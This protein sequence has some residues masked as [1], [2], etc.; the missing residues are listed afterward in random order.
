L[1]QCGS[2][3][4][5]AGIST[6]GRRPGA[7]VRRIT[8]L[9]QAGFRLEVDGAVAVVDP[10]LSPHEHRLIAS[11]PLELAADGVD[12]LLVTHEH[13]DH[14]DLAFLPILL[15]RSPEARVVVPE[16]V[17]ALVEGLVPEARLVL[18]QPHDALEVA[19]AELHVTPAYH[20]VS[21]EDPYGDGSGI[22]GRPRFVG[23]ALGS[24]RRV[25]HAGD[26]IV[27]GDLGDAVARLDVGVAL[28]PINGRDAERE[29]RG[30]VGNMDAVEAVDLALA[31]GASVLVPYHWDGVSGNTVPPGSAVDAAA[32]RLHVLV[33]AHFRPIELAAAEG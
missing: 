20:G 25:Y 27:M 13:L 30:I 16:P 17:A 11:P 2:I 33:P 31:V 29:A 7:E 19:G 5:G 22:G 9:G 4:S 23:Y 21:P 28:L 18:V 10:W 8:W 32:G 3:V 1:E 12:V 6:A 26:T 14:L 24:A 15:E